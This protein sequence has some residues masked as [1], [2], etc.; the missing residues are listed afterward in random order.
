MSTIAVFCARRY[1]CHPLEFVTDKSSGYCTS[2]LLRFGR[3]NRRKRLFQRHPRLKAW[4]ILENCGGCF[5]SSNVQF[6]DFVTHRSL[7]AAGWS[8]RTGRGIHI[9]NVV[10]KN[11][12]V[13][14]KGQCVEGK[15]MA[16]VEFVAYQTNSGFVVVKVGRGE[17]V[18][19]VFSKL[20]YLD[21][22]PVVSWWTV[23][24]PRTAFVV[25][26]GGR[27]SRKIPQV[28]YLNDGF[29][30][31]KAPSIAKSGSWFSVL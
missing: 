25:K 7:G 5:S 9:D 1:P 18:G 8:R 10:R 14:V 15:R 22:I 28:E 12:V 20:D 31:D 11:R 21:R 24:V 13:F 16:F 17:T 27:H 3:S 26:G 30:S 23:E 2:I 4:Y 29:R 19:T 6:G